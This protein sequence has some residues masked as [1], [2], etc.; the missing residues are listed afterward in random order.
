MLVKELMKR[1]VATVGPD[2]SLA[3]H[4]DH[5]YLLAFGHSRIRP[6]GLPSPVR[7]VTSGHTVLPRPR[8]A[9]AG[10]MIAEHPGLTKARHFL[11]DRQVLGLGERPQDIRYRLMGH[12]VKHDQLSALLPGEVG[13][14]VE[15]L[16]AMLRAVDRRQDLLG[17]VDTSS[18]LRTRPP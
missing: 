9:R 3:A 13:R 14:Q 2:P 5:V 16:P 18:S 7:P 6:P 15:R 1:V 17:H 11:L 4:D 8:F 12:H 10:Q